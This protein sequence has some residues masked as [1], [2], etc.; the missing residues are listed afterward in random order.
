M[1]HE[2]I[3]LRA[4]L[5]S[6]INFESL[7]SGCAGRERRSSLPIGFIDPWVSQTYTFY[8]RATQEPNAFWFPGAA[9]AEGGAPP[10]Q[11]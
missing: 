6:W 10:P 11:S 4:L 9:V 2:V 8:A 7:R 5:R 3:C 1:T